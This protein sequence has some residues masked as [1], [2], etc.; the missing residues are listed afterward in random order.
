MTK[1]RKSGRE[2]LENPPVELPKV[3]EVPEKWRKSQGGRFVLVP[4]PLM[5]DAEIRTVRKGKQPPRIA[6]FEKAV[7]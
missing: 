1:M 3:V 7:A 5:T 2:K 6:D 4:T